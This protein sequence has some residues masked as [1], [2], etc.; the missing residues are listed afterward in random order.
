MSPPLTSLPSPPAPSGPPAVCLAFPAPSG[1]ERGHRNASSIHQL[2]PPCH[3]FTLQ[4]YCTLSE[5][6]PFQ[7]GHPQNTSSGQRNRSHGWQTLAEL[8]IQDALPFCSGSPFPL[9]FTPSLTR[10]LFL[11]VSLFVCVSSRFLLLYLPAIL[12]HTLNALFIWTLI[13]LRY[14]FF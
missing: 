7:T 13:Y 9:S 2:L 4:L 8:H 11:C 3:R 10:S 14:L 12:I 5:P 6:R 1:R